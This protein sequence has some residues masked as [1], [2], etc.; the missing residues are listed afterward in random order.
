MIIKGDH[1]WFTDPDNDVSSGIYH[2][3]SVNG[4][5]YCLSNKDN[6]VNIEAF[7][8]E[9]ELVYSV[10]R[11]RDITVVIENGVCVDVVGLPEE[12]KYIVQDNDN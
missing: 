2:V 9:L 6:T 1:V 8:S 5:V 10:P 7:E 4:S 3:D 12:W 11:E